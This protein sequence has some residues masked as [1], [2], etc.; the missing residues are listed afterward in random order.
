[1]FT[2]AKLGD[3]IESVLQYKGQTVWSVSPHASVSEA[4]ECPL[5]N[6][7]ATAPASHRTRMSDH[8]AD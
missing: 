7:C 8:P 5:S 1:M 3:K 6:D 2:P 4:I